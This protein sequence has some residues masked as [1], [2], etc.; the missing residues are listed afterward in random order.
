MTSR[1]LTASLILLSLAVAQSNGGSNSGSLFRG[2]SEFT[3][4]PRLFRQADPDIEKKDYE[5]VK[6][7]ASNIETESLVRLYFLMTNEKLR[8]DT[9]ANRYGRPNAYTNMFYAYQS[10]NFASQKHQ[11]LPFSLK[12]ID[13]ALERFHEIRTNL[14]LA[15]VAENDV[16]RTEF[17]LRRIAGIV[18]FL[19]AG[20]PSLRTAKDHFEAILKEISLG[21]KE[22]VSDQELG[23]TYAF[24]VATLDQ[25]YREAAPTDLRAA[26][27]Y[28]RIMVYHLW[29]YTEFRVKGNE[30]LLEAKLLEILRTYLPIL[31]PESKEYIEVYKPYVEKLGKS[32]AVPGTTNTAPSGTS[33]T[34]K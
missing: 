23:D 30:K 29:R 26:T 16:H 12:E 5:V 9:L 20:V 22:A 15:G 4:V 13:R 24:L 33:S 2:F 14:V 31:D 11:A 19:D 6:N 1:I 7:I 28:L 18:Y 21:A 10:A 32:Y 3:P 8:V 25:L 34:N 17:R 27:Y